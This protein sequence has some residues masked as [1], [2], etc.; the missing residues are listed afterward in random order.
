MGHVGFKEAKPHAWSWMALVGRREGD[1]N[2]WFCGGALINEQWVLTALHCL[3]ESPDVVRLGEHD[4]QDTNDG[5]PHQDFDVAETV[6]YPG[7][8]NPEGYHDLALLRLSSR[9]HIQKFFIPVCLPWGVEREVDITGQTATLTGGPPT[10]FLQQVKVTVFTSDKCDTS[11]SILPKYNTSWPQGIG[12]ETLCAGDVEG[13]KDACQGDS[14]GP[15]VTK[16]VGGSF[17]LAGIV[18]QGNGCGNKDFPGLYANMRYP[19][20]LVWIKNVAF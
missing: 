8:A 19:P 4:Y 11:Y 9:V 2:K 3:F 17:V 13:G 1:N 20:Y 16:D 15:L 5:A 18:V 7:Y 12:E 6:M 14:G 10:T